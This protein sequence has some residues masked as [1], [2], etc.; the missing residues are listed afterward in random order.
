MPKYPCTAHLPTICQLKQPQ[1]QTPCLV[2]GG[3]EVSALTGTESAIEPMHPE[4]HFWDF[5]WQMY[6]PCDT[7]NRL[8][9]WH[10]RFFFHLKRTSEIGRWTTGTD[11]RAPSPGRSC[12][13]KS[14]LGFSRRLP[15]GIYRIKIAA[16][17]PFLKARGAGHQF[18][19]KFL[20]AYGNPGCRKKKQKTLITHQMDD[21]EE[22]SEGDTRGLKN[23]R[24]H[25]LVGKCFFFVTFG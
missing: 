23:T 13:D 18:S 11:H 4:P 24:T 6:I 3:Q 14:C 7:S 2:L 16:G 9:L 25:R 20:F 8:S 17:F 22:H 12:R 19:E 10:S 5:T 15:C 1:T 21:D